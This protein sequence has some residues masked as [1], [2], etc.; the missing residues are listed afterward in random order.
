[1][2]RMPTVGMIGAGG[3]GKST[4]MKIFERDGFKALP[5][6][7]R[8]YFAKHNLKSEVEYLKLPEP[9]KKDFQTGMMDFYMERF[10]KFKEAN[11]GEALVADR[12]A[13]DHLGYCLCSIPTGFTL[14]EIDHWFVRCAEFIEQHFTHIIF[15][16]YPNL[17]MRD[18]SAEDGFRM[19]AAAKQ[20]TIDAM[21]WRLLHRF[22]HR[23]HFQRLHDGVCLLE[24]KPSHDSPEELY[25]KIANRSNNWAFVGGRYA[26]R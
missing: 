24:V 26:V 4:L 9:A 14:A 2:P 20:Y 12:T 6:T 10:E 21:Y 16:P 17:W 25:K 13:F 15:I 18:D 3:T 8:D 7:S 1:M 22:M 23:E 5:S 11:K 19:T